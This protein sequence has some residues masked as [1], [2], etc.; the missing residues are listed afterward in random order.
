MASSLNQTEL[1][2]ETATAQSPRDVPEG[3]IEY[4]HDAQPGRVHT[5]KWQNCCIYEEPL[6]EE[7]VAHSL[8]LGAVWVAYRPDLSTEQV[9]LLRNIVRGELQP[10]LKPLVLLSPQPGAPCRNGIGQPIQ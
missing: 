1:P 3:E 8:A 9:E 4:E 7:P 2:A 5:N 6:A 10:G